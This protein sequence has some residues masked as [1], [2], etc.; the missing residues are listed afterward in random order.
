MAKTTINQIYKNIFTQEEINSIYNAI[1]KSHNDSTV[2][3]PIYRQKAY[4]TDLPQSIKDRVTNLANEIFDKKLKLTEICFA[5]Y[6]MREGMEDPIL[7]PHFDNT[8]EEER[9]TIDVQLK[10]NIKWPIVVEG[11]PFTLN[12]NEAVT[13]SGTHQIHWREDRKFNK[14]DF[15]DMLFCHFSEDSDSPLKISLQ[16]RM[17]TENSAIFWINKFYQDIMK[18]LKNE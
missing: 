4:F 14:D 1:E 2:V 9:F 15:I 3:L 11:K 6:S 18:R 7:S 16:E 17:E 12:D 8:F 10:S 13:F 5:N